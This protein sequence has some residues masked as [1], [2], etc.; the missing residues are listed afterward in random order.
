MTEP[1]PETALPEPRWRRIPE[2]R[3]RQILEAAFEVF[4]EKG[5]H[6]ARLDD[7]ARR[8]GVAKGTI[9]LYFPNKEALFREMIQQTIVERLEAARR[10]LDANPASAGEQLRAYMRGWWAF[11]RSAEYQTVYR[12]IHAELPRFPDLA[13]FYAHEVVARYHALVGGMIQRGID[14]GEFRPVDPTVATRMLSS[15][16]ITQS[17]WCANRKT[18]S[19]FA[20]MSSET[21]LADIMDFYFR[22]LEPDR[23]TG[24]T[25]Q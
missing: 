20:S 6:A 22:A 8:A 16:M 25:S 19:P 18:L 10:D 11:L 13:R 2:E 5:L 7:I 15:I 12:L 1:R 24:R 14:S 21:M 3:P 4:G 23:T 17:L 9:Y